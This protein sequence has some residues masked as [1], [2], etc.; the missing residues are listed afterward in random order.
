MQKKLVI[1]IVLIC[2]LSVTLIHADEG[3]WLLNSLK[4]LPWKQMQAHGLKLTPEQIYN[5]DGV[6]LADAIVQIGGGTGSFV[7]DQGLI[8]TNH[9]V[10]FGAIQRQS[11][12]DQDFIRKGF[13]AATLAE[14]LPAKGYNARIC[15]GFQDVTA[16][17][18]KHVN[19]DMPYGERYTTIE[20]IKRELLKK[21]EEDET[22]SAQI[23]EMLSGTHYYLF[24]YLT[25]KDVRIVYAPP[26]SVGEYGGD[27]DNWMWPRHTGDFSFM[28]AYVGPDGKPADY[29][30][31]N[32]PFKPKKYLKVSLDGVNE[33]DFTM[34]IGYPGNTMRYRCSFSIDLW[35]NETYPEQI[36]TFRKNIKA[37]EELAGDNRELQIKYAARIKG[38]NNVLK[39]N[40]GMVEGLKK[41]RLLERKQKQEAE[42]TAFLKKNPELDKKYG[43]VLP[44]LGRIY[45]ELR[46][47]H[48]KQT[49]LGN[50][51][52]SSDLLANARFIY[53]WS[54]EK[55]KNES[56]REPGYTE[57]N[58]ERIKKQLTAGRDQI[59]IPAN[60]K[61]LAMTL[62]DAT[63][64]PDN[65][66]IRA[67]E[68]LTGGKSG[69][70]LNQAI[71]NFVEDIFARTV[72]TDFDRA[73]ELMDKTETEIN[74]LND[75][76]IQLAAKLEEE[77]KEMNDKYEAFVGAVFK[78][79]P[80]LIRGIY[81]WKKGSLYPD[82]NGT[83][84]FTYGYVKGYNPRDA[85]SYNWNTT[86]K[87]VIEKDTGEE[88]FDNPVELTELYQKKDFGQYF[89]ADLNDVPVNFLHDTDITG[90]NS[91]SPV[92][93]G[94]GE[95]IGVVFDGDYESMTS[96]FQFNPE[97]TRTIS[98]DV[99][100][101]LFI[102]EKLGK[103]THLLKEMN[104]ATE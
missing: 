10:A 79:R 46:T 25:L 17:I 36:E 104:V 56:E 52:G 41:S 67:L 73:M 54:I 91:G 63:N 102:T 35:Q 7:S 14:E 96:D 23:V 29:S 15:T 90:G 22:I 61:L 31:K 78:L 76:I 16:E 2:L 101:A 34:V 83:V 60:K 69:D 86:L 19:D 94:K 64:L 32:V 87:G 81:E 45:D 65:Q 26:R 49:S 18:L 82:A 98:V 13:L 21:Y 80:S 103:A 1:Q 30:E 4:Q 92:L 9:H 43:S 99:R 57:K 53:K 88:P 71:H 84:R 95:L 85:V 70:D 39:N 72:F 8:I 27:I 75:P 97:L 3:M 20:N 93:N 5:P 28:R 47:Y 74:A 66:K 55:Q 62:M 68:G 48:K 40:E 6:S 24:T 12:A 42:F 37:L 50:I 59:D 100:Y 77:N 38:L 51:L 11:S 33:N 58:I 44:E 89:D